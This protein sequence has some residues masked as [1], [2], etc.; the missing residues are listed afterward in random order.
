M[1][2]TDFEQSLALFLPE[3][4]LKEGQD[5]EKVFRDNMTRASHFCYFEKLKADDF[6][7]GVSGFKGGGTFQ[8][9]C[10][11]IGVSVKPNVKK[12]LDRIAEEGQRIIQSQDWSPPPSSSRKL[13]SKRKVVL[14]TWALDAPKSFYAQPPSSMIITENAVKTHDQLHGTHERPMWGRKYVMSEGRWIPTKIKV[15]LPAL[16]VEYGAWCIMATSKGHLS[17]M[18]H[19]TMRPQV[20]WEKQ[21]NLG[22]RYRIAR[23][24]MTKHLL[25][26]TMMVSD[27]PVP[28]LRIWTYD[29]QTGAILQEVNHYLTVND[30]ILRV[31]EHPHSPEWLLIATWSRRL[32][33]VPIAPPS[34]QTT[35]EPHRVMEIQDLPTRLCVSPGNSLCYI[36]TPSHVDILIIPPPTLAPDQGGVIQRLG[37]INEP[38]IAFVNTH[39]GFMI[40]VNH[41]FEIFVTLVG[42]WDLKMIPN[43]SRKCRYGLDQKDGYS[44]TVKQAI[45]MTDD[46][47]MISFPN[48]A[49]RRVR[50]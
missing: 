39:K 26:A 23:L 30:Y 17:M 49:V 43:L 13:N 36:C 50:A 21:L 37:V 31:D 19:G 7:H 12:R 44:S 2:V 34:V 27:C 3:I 8:L 41:R 33:V 10:R 16:L 6:C 4:E 35:L 9:E 18:T 15:P 47:F 28:V 22:D 32:L 38:G 20:V 14:T 40:L 11:S 5:A 42:L 25:I 48:G 29:Q 46:G 1:E 24:S 45:S